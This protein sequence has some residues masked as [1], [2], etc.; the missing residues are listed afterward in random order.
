MS[1]FIIR[2]N[3]NIIII[4]LFSIMPLIDSLNGFMLA[5]GTG[6]ISMVYKVVCCAILIGM[7]I[8]HGKIIK[9]LFIIS[10][11]FILYLIFSVGINLMLFQME[12]FK[13]DFVV[14][15]LFNFILF[16]ALMQNVKNEY[17]AGQTFY[18]IL[19]NIT[20]LMILC[21]FIPYLGGMGYQTY[22]GNIGYKA[23]FY[24]QN[25]LSLAIIV[26]FY[27]CIYK[28]IMQ[29]KVSTIVQLALLFLAGILLNTKSCIIAC[30]V[31]I[32]IWL[33]EILTKKP[34]RNKLI[35]VV[36]LIVGL[37]LF[38]DIVVNAV[39]N[40]LIRANVLSQ[41]Y[42][43]SFTATIMS[44]RNYNLEG[45]WNELMNRP[46]VLLHIII[47]NGFNSNF[48][49]E[50]DI[51]DLFF[52]LGIIGVI[53]AVIFLIYIFIQSIPNFKKDRS[54]VR[55]VAYL[56]IVAFL[57]L[58]G[59]VLFMGMS[60]FYFVI[61]SCFNMTYNMNEKLSIWD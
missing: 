55:G 7:L 2:L 36:L 31:G 40:S 25:E 38:R 14:K 15:L 45:A 30:I 13:G 19:N 46:L 20:W 34:F 42:N 49:I 26:L 27:F 52:Y 50:M 8:K 12:I 61:F 6:S 41:Y 60:G 17:L 44:G 58:T 32:I 39:Q 35:S 24:S 48:L 18:K 59:H 9:K 29:I 4:C 5:E 33:V 3:L 28:M 22:T 43:N 54:I 16:A 53:F 11:I 37:W 57:S 1:R 56:F 10:N 47:G 51:I 23:F 21:F